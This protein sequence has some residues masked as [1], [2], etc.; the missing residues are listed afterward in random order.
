MP[1]LAILCVL[2]DFLPQIQNIFTRVYPSYPWHFATLMGGKWWKKMRPRE[3]VGG[4][5]LRFPGLC[6]D[7]GTFGGRLNWGEKC[8]AL[9]IPAPPCRIVALHKLSHWCY[10]VHCTLMLYCILYTDATLYIVHWC[11]IALWEVAD[12]Y[13]TALYCLL[14]LNCTFKQD[15]VNC[16]TTNWTKFGEGHCAVKSHQFEIKW[17][18]SITLTLC[19]KLCKGSQWTSHPPSITDHIL[20]Q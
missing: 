1:N 15:T 3:F 6:A 18:V 13:I 7:F 19:M 16:L 12:L 4:G 11:Y 9:N 17:F 2:S 10:I 8:V 5:G 14:P 20:H